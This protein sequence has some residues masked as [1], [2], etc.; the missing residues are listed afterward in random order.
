MLT[1]VTRMIR[2]ARTPKASYMV[3]HPVK[4]TRALVAARGLR[5]IVTSRAGATLAGMVVV[6]LGLAA[7]RARARH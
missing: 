6:P 5:G 2:R 7:L 3:K 1:H 4:A